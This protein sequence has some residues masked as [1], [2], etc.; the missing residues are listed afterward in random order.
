MSVR[1]CPTCRRVKDSSLF[2]F[3]AASGNSRDCRKCYRKKARMGGVDI[4]RI[5]YK[6]G[7]ITIKKAA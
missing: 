1:Q 5:H 6:L 7:A 2:R 3:A 4:D